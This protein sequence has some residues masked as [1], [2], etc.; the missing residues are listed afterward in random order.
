VSK[1]KWIKAK[2]YWEHPWGTHWEPGEH[3][4][5]VMGNHWELEGNMLG[6]KKKMKKTK[7]RIL[8]HSE[9]ENL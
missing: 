2:C 8:K 9:R 3:I 1:K 4:E 6:T 7:F 5:I